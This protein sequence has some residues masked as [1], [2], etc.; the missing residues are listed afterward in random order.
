MTIS[1]YKPVNE[2]TE[3]VY[4]SGKARYARTINPDPVYEKWSIAIYP[5]Q[6]EMPKVHDL[7]NKGIRNKLKKD[8]DGYFITFSRPLKIKLRNGQVKPMEGP[9][10]IDKD[11]KIITDFIGDGSDV[12]VKL[13]TYGGPGP[14]GKGSY[15][16]ARLQGIKVNSLVPHTKE[17]LDDEGYEQVSGLQEQP[18]PW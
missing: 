15:Y 2:K 9:K 11:G 6:S 7:L 4:I 13:E 12:T 8:D 5:P 18:Q 14:G 3:A 1:N 10:V 16:A 17:Q